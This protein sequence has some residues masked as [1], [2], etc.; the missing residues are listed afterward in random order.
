MIR[1]TI[2][3]ISLTCV[4]IFCIASSCLAAYY[5]EDS[6]IT[7]EYNGSY[8]CERA[9][10]DVHTTMQDYTVH[11]GVEKN[12]LLYGV[13]ATNV[14]AGYYR[15]CYSYCVQGTGGTVYVSV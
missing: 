15:T 2:T 3:T 5:F 1:K 9:W 14:P 11:V 13:K 6:G 7:S 10:V 4:V 8:W 12:G